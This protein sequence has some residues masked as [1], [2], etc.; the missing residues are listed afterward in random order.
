M[1]AGVR[2]DFGD[3]DELA[4]WQS[5]AEQ[6]ERHAAAATRARD[7]AFATASNTAQAKT[8]SLLAEGARRYEA[9]IADLRGKADASARQ[10]VEFKAATAK[11]ESAL[12]DERRKQQ[13]EVVT[14]KSY[15]DSAKK[16]ETEIAELQR[17]L[18]E[19][20]RQADE[21]QTQACRGAEDRGGKSR[22]PTCWRAPQARD[23]GRLAQ[24]AIR[25][26]QN[27]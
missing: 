1:A 24:V 23:R 8:Q 9:E 10:L 3:G 14:L 20:K 25:K 7:E 13:A 6:A 27:A 26:C 19:A 11:A 4:E 18:D 2:D 21:V 15:S 22:R 17:K 12:A 5:R 16:H